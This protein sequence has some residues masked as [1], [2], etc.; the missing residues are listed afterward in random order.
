MARRGLAARTDRIDSAPGAESYRP[1]EFVHFAAL[2][3]RL[4]AF[5][6]AKV[7]HFGAF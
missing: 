2:Y 4:R 1:A 7:V 3:D 5:K 6:D